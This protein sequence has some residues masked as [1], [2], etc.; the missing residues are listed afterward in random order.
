MHGAVC[1]RIFYVVARY[2]WTIL[3]D[4][5]LYELG[6]AKNYKNMLLESGLEYLI[7]LTPKEGNKIYLNIFR[8]IKYLQYL[9]RNTESVRLWHI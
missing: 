2:N 7:I 9:S 8:I 3:F 4:G 1:F 6:V 5:S